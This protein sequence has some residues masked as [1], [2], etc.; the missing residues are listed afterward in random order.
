MIS[1]NPNLIP[2]QT[3]NTEAISPT[4]PTVSNSLGSTPPN[5]ADFPDG[6]D[7]SAFQQA[8]AQYAAAQQTAASSGSTNNLTH[9]D[10]D[11]VMLQTDSIALAE[12]SLSFQND[13]YTGIFLDFII[14]EDE[15]QPNTLLYTFTFAA[16]KH[17]DNI[18][19]YLAAGAGVNILQMLG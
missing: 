3:G 1:S 16:R 15:E 17:S 19:G 10:S 5:P 12:V 13:T 14:E 18:G 11:T 4:G 9:T 8:A 7:G 2:I 6:A